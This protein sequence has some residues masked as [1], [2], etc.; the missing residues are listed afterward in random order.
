MPKTRK[1]PPVYAEID[2][3]RFRVTIP[4]VEMANWMIE[5]EA[6]FKDLRPFIARVSDEELE[7]AYIAAGVKSTCLQEHDRLMLR[8]K[9]GDAPGKISYFSNYAQFQPVLCPVDADGNPTDELKLDNPDG[10]PIRGGTYYDWR[11]APQQGWSAESHVQWTGAPYNVPAMM[12]LTNVDPENYIGDTYDI[13]EP[14][15]TLEWVAYNGLLISRYQLG[16]T[17]SR[18]LWVGGYLQDERRIEKCS[19]QK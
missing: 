6:L 2:G 19:G 11:L 16:M 1:G 9:H 8:H 12:W 15:T 5:H 3:V 17:D 13:T 7:A 4:D 14:V 18:V 10:S